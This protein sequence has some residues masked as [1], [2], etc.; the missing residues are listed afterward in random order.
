MTS[1]QK[2][3][4]ELVD[5]LGCSIA[6]AKDIIATDKIIDKGGRTAYDLSKEDEKIAKKWAN[7]GVRKQP[8][9][10]KFDKK[11]TK[12]ANPTKEGIISLLAEC[13]KDCELNIENLE[14]P[15][16]GKLITFSLDGN[17]F[18][19]DLKQKRAKK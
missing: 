3:I 8:T 2:R 16:S 19:L 17:N 9:V 4:D 7:A 10:Y 18:E 6:E 12:K 13:L 15:N 1:E 11:S 5:K 14:I